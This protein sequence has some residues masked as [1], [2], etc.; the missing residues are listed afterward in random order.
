MKYA[1]LYTLALLA[2]MAQAAGPICV[3]GVPQS[4]PDSLYTL[5]D[6][7]ATVTDHRT[8]LTWLRC[9]IGQSGD[10]C[11]VGTAQGKT[12]PQALEAAAQAN[13]DCFF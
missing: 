2:P 9:A 1:L 11:S 12:W 10:D 4:K 6:D 5:S 13:Q 3:E 7:K 8:G